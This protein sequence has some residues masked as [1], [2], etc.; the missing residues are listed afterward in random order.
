MGRQRHEVVALIVPTT[1]VVKEAIDYD[2]R[3]LRSHW[4]YE[5]FAISGDAVLAFVGGVD[6]RGPHLVDLADKQAGLFIA[7]RRMLHII[8]E[9]FGPD[10]DR[11]V[12]MQRLLVLLATELLRAHGVLGQRRSGDDIFIG[13]GKLSV[14]IATVS[15]VSCLVHFG[16]NVTTEG[17]PVRTSALAD[18]GIDPYRFAEELTEAYAREIGSMARATVKVRSVP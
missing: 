4:I 13:D 7:G 2:G 16:I 18:H 15:L 17:T 1:R 10:L 12:F 5:N 8:A 3:Q 14:S 6:V 11:A 9:S